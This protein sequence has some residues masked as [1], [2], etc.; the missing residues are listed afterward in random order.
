MK[1]RNIIL[2]TL[3]FA[4][5]YLL[6]INEVTVAGSNGVNAN[7]SSLGA[8]FSA[9]NGAGTQSGNNITVAIS[10]SISEG[11]TATLNA[12][13]WASLT[14][15]PTASSVVVSAN[16][17]S[18]MIV[19]NGTTKVT[20]NGCVNNGV[21]SSRDLTITNTGGASLWLSTTILF[22]SNATNNT[23][24][25]C[26]VKGSST[27]YVNGTIHFGS[28]S[29]ANGNGSNTINNNLLTNSSESHRPVYSIYSQ[30]SSAGNANAANIISN[31]D[32]ANFVNPTLSSNAIYLGTNNNAF[33]ITGNNFYETTSFAPSA[34]SDVYYAAIS[35]TGGTGYTVNDNFIG[36]SATGCGGRWTKL[37]GTSGFNNE[38]TGIYLNLSSGGTASTVQNNTIQN[39]TWTTT[40]NGLFHGISIG[41][42][43]VNIGSVTAN[44][45]GDNT[46]T[47]SIVFTD[48]IAVLHSAIYIASTGVVNC[49][50]NKIGSIT[51][52]NSVPASYSSDFLAI[53][54]TASAGVTS[55]SNNVIGGSISN[56]INQNSATTVASTL[57][58]IKCDGTDNCTISTNTITN[59]YSASLATTSFV[60]GISCSP[61]TCSGVTT[62]SN[63]IVHDLSTN[64]VMQQ[65]W[66]GVGGI[67][68]GSINAVSNVYN[69]TVYNLSSSNASFAG[70]ITGIIATGGTGST[71]TNTFY[72]NLIYGISTSS[73][74]AT[75]VLCGIRFG[76]NVNLFYN[77]I[78]YITG[79]SNN[80]VIGFYESNS[81]FDNAQT[82]TFYYNTVYLSGAPTSGAINTYCFWQSQ[83][84]YTRVIKNNIF[85]NVRTNN[86]ATG[87]NFTIGANSTG[88]TINYNDYY[89][90][91]GSGNDYLAN[92]NGTWKQTF[93]NWQT[94]T[95]QDGSSVNVNPGF[96]SAGGTLAVNYTPSSASLV[97]VAGTGVSTDY[98]AA[99]RSSYTMGAYNL[100]SVPGAP[101]IGTATVGDTKASISF[102]IPLSDGGSPI[103]SYTATST[104]G[105]F[106][107]S[108]A[109]SP[110]V[111]TGLLN[112]T[113]YT[114]AVTATNT[115][116]TG[117]ASSSSN[118]V[119]PSANISVTASQ[120]ISS[121]LYTASSDITVSSSGTLTINQDATV[122]NVTLN[123]GSKLD[124]GN[125]TLSVSNLII[126]SDKTTAPS[127]KVTHA[128]SVSG[129]VTLQKTL[130]NTKWYFLS[131]PS[132]VAVDNITQ[133]S[134]T[135]VGTISGLGAGG[136][137][138][139]IK[140]YDGASRAT[141]LGA[142]SNWVAVAAGANLQANKGYAIGLA[143]ALTG[144]HVLSIPLA[145][146]LVTAAEIATT[147]TVGL[148]GEGT[149]VAANHIGWNLVGVPYLS[150]FP[151][152]GVGA[153]YLTFYNGA[154][155]D[156]FDKASVSNITPFSSFF[157]QASAAGSTV[158]LPFTLGSRQLVKSIVET[159][160]ADRVQINVNTETG[161]DHTN[162]IIED[163]QT[164]AYEINQDL[165]K[166]ISTGTDKPQVYTVLGG[167]NYAYNALPLNSTQNLPLSIYTKTAGP[168]TIA[169]D[170]SQAAGVS[171]LLLTDNTTAITTDLLTSDYRYTSLA[172]TTNDRFTLSAKRSAAITTS[173]EVLNVDQPK[174]RMVD[175]KLLVCGVKSNTV[176]KVF[177]SVG[178]L[179]ANK[180]TGNLEIP[181][182]TS[183]IYIVN[184]QCGG[185]NQI[186]KVVK[187]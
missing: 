62:V 20:I 149:G 176:I 21:G 128:M 142:T 183:G 182:P 89:I 52:A 83:T 78:I 166:W 163:T 81:A 173:S 63:N 172:G 2:F 14:I 171:Q 85:V 23:I 66:N 36:G 44:S 115:R 96:A 120:N 137:T 99:N 15:Y 46:T 42:G 10:A 72:N 53:Y 134:T 12:G 129:T 144:D 126:Q 45:I 123:S 3:L 30:G 119:T 181:L 170:V 177:N 113:S 185:K 54:K 90:G 32:F 155:Y 24:K 38:F 100:A 152:S 7:Y 9:I 77:N 117:A 76:N 98:A 92:G 114:F 154:T 132:T 180:E 169:V 25:N 33:S 41:N 108:G 103:T 156:Q 64:A 67:F 133:L 104:P 35:I 58:G 136:A 4:F 71:T 39:I 17:S 61:T 109:S 101:I 112:G 168:V 175:G 131:F 167:V 93:G 84:N 88:L 55:I 48:G 110:L 102:S 118:A 161:T 73:T 11:S 26:I 70:V 151:G 37:V 28:S 8:A 59:L 106:N 121:L 34:T 135:G 74:V 49:N 122:H 157:I 107:V 145:N 43:D 56:S 178:R 27:S 127:I 16:L 29:A 105:G 111:V 138:W 146:T 164:A 57:I 5:Q 97:G 6:A 75:T 186:A 125:N 187:E 159:D 130:D 150:N 87:K 80:E 86:G 140:Q 50:N 160:A 91:G 82:N 179:I 116:G 65:Y 165:S 31:N 162:L 141:N 19:L 51:V 143:D 79:N 174:I 22:Q 18:D 69:N 184:L 139:Y 124:L 158:N 95:G 68:L 94:Y 153:N 147:V 1:P 60:A 13:D 40:N 47:G 148:Y